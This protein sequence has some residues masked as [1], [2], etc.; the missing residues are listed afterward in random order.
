MDIGTPANGGLDPT[1][2]LPGAVGPLTAP[3]VL[4]VV[5]AV[6][7]SLAWWRSRTP[8]GRAVA[9]CL[10]A[11]ACASLCGLAVQGL[12]LTSP[13]PYGGWKRVAFHAHEALGLVST[14]ALAWV[15]VD[16]L[17]PPAR[18]LWP[19]FAGCWA[20][21]LAA[22]V[23]TYPEVR[24]EDLR[25]V[26]LLLEGVA[27]FT[28]ATAVGCWAARGAW[29]SKWSAAVQTVLALTAADLVLL[30]VGA[31]PRGLFGRAYA[32]QQAGLAALYLVVAAVNARA[33]LGG[34][35]GSGP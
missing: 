8:A 25:R 21:A 26:L 30:A 14:T 29:R 23:L 28:A 22:L 35:R 20:A 32:V 18:R 10:T 11:T 9:L 31:W 12:W 2:P 15:A 1:P 7:A 17:T 34:E 6:L 33:L 27:V 13:G 3:H 16:V 5:A 24:G 19:G 4:L